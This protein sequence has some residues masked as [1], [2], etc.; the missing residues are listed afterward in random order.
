MSL[1]RRGTITNRSQ[2]GILRA[3]RVRVRDVATVASFSIAGYAEVRY[4]IKQP[5]KQPRYV[6]YKKEINIKNDHRPYRCLHYTCVTKV[7]TDA[8]VLHSNGLRYQHHSEKLNR[9][10]A[11]WPGS[12]RN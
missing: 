6:Q 3:G 4:L 8:F 9:I 5:S 10:R 2:P 11:D 1:V 12:A 7:S